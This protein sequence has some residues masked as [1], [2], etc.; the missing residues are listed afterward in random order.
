M[1]GHL[2]T[3]AAFS[4]Q[5]ALLFPGIALAQ[6]ST[7]SAPEISNDHGAIHH[8]V[9]FAAS[10]KR[11]YE[12]L[13]QTA[14]FD[15]VVRLSSAMKDGFSPDKAP[16]EIA[17]QTG[18]T[19]SLFAGY[20]TGRHLELVPNVRIV[21]AWRTA[22][23]AAGD[24]SIVKFALSPSGSQTKLVFDHTGFPAG[25]AESL[26]HGW[27]VNYWEPLAKYLAMTPA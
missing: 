2:A 8:E 18:G 11:V 27:H 23:W 7:S 12:A 22:R 10:P 6:T 15:Q 26:N 16:T 14:R 5:L 24:Y 13:T 19:F 25:E 20:I 21:Q 17:K 9:A 4:A 1:L 3:R